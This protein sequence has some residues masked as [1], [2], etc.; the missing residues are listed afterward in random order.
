MITL[1]NLYPPT[2][3]K[4]FYV[5]HFRDLRVCHISFQTTKEWPKIKKINKEE[6]AF[7]EVFLEAVFMTILIC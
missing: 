3:A 4:F 1:L 2:N 6:V 5:F 7:H